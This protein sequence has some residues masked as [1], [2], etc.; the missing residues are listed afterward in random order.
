MSKTNEKDVVVKDTCKANLRP[1]NE[2]ILVRV[3]GAAKESPGGI[4]LPDQAQEKPRRGTVLAGV[5]QSDIQGDLDAARALLAEIAAIERGE[6][7]Q[8]A[9]VG[10]AY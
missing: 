8:R 3:E 6:G 10:N 5:L 9:A 2:K 1:L 4:L 7:P